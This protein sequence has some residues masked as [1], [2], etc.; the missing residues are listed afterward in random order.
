MWRAQR[1]P[2]Y[3][4]RKVQHPRHGSESAG[5]HH[6]APRRMGR[7]S[8]RLRSPFQPHAFANAH[9]RRQKPNAAL[10]HTHSW[11]KQPA[12][13]S[14]HRPAVE[15]ARPPAKA[16][17]TLPR[18]NHHYIHHYTPSSNHSPRH[19]A[20]RGMPNSRSNDRMN[21]SHTPTNTHTKRRMGRTNTYD[22]KMGRTNRGKPDSER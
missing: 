8:C 7:K 11:R 13:P 3:R 1:H 4:H 17:N 2:P 5:L 14:P 16:G 15:T 6:H 9:R 10:A 18:S 21:S 12:E 22:S 20:R 19:C